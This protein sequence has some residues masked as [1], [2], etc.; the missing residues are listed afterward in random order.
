MV[1]VVIYISN[2]CSACKRAVS[3]VKSISKE[4]NNLSY[5]IKNIKH[6][7]KKIFVVPAIFINNELFCYGEFETKTLQ[8]I[9]QNI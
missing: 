4:Y 2:N 6:S 9:I 1:S 7:D 5:E 8:H 3:K